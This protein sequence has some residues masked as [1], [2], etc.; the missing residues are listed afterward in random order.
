[1][2]RSTHCGQQ[3]SFCNTFTQLIMI[4]NHDIMITADFIMIGQPGNDPPF[5][6]NPPLEVFCIMITAG[7]DY[8][9]DRGVN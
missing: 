2:S 4:R 7:F 9:Y 8:D 6:T 3:I 1:M 5:L